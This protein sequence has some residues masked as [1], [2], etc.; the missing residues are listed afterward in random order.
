[1]MLSRPR[2]RR[3]RRPD[4]DTGAALILAVAF[5][6]MVGAISAGLIGLATSSLSNRI[7]LDRVRDREYAADGA[8]SQAISNVRLLTAPGLISCGLAGGSIV[9]GSMN[10]VAIRV[11]WTNSCGVVQGVEGTVA[12]RR[13]VIFAACEDKGV[14]CAGALVIIRAE[15]NL[16]QASTGLVTKTYVQSWSVNR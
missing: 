12:A 14:T 13:N 10:G 2:W 7:T 3:P 8:I 16:E 6:L 5:V 9:D 1:M 11:D 15:V 4:D